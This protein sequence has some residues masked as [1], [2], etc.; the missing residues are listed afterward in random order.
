VSL[1]ALPGLPALIS[2]LKGMKTSDPTYVNQPKRPLAQRGGR[3]SDRRP[4]NLPARAAEPQG[5]DDVAAPRLRDRYG[6]DHASQRHDIWER[7]RDGSWACYG[8]RTCRGGL[9]KFNHPPG[10]TGL[11]ALLRQER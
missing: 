7:K 9:E 2:N 11:I 8:G 5:S 6:S 3:Q 10:L 1:E 4:A